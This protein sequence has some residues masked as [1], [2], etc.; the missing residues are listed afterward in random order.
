EIVQGLNRVKDSFNSYPLGSLAQAGATAAIQDVAY[1]QQTRQAVIDARECLT[2]QLFTLGFQVLP[3]RANFVFAR[4][5]AVDG[6]ELSRALRAQNIL[7]R[8]FKLPRIDQFL[9][10]TVGTPDDCERLCNTLT[11]ILAKTN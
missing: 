7:V 3:S 1:F 5:P 2:K 6:T 11:K 10:I 9:R 4:H 8:H